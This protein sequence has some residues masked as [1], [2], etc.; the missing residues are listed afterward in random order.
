MSRCPGKK[1]W[2]KPCLLKSRKPLPRLPLRRGSAAS[3][4]APARV[5]HLEEKSPT[6]TESVPRG[7]NQTLWLLIGGGVLL[8]IVLVV[9][10]LV[11]VQGPSQPTVVQTGIPTVSAI[12]KDSRIGTTTPKSVPQDTG[13]HPGT[14][15][16]KPSPT[17][18]T[19]KEGLPALIQPAKP[20]DRDRLWAEFLD[21]WA[22]DSEPA[23]QTP[24]LRVGRLLTGLPQNSGSLEAAWQAAAADRLTILEIN[25]NGPLYL[26]TLPAVHGRSL[27]LRAGKGYRPLLIWEPEPGR[28]EPFIEFQGGSLTL[29]GLDVAVKATNLMGKDRPFLVRVRDGDF[30][31]R[32]CTF[33]VAGQ[34]ALGVALVRLDRSQPGGSSG[35]GRCRLSRCFGRGAS[36]VALDL[37]FPGAQVLLEGCLLVGSEQPLIQVTGRSGPPPV[38]RVVRSTLVTGQGMMVV[39]PAENQTQP[40]LRWHGWDVLLACGGGQPGGALLAVAGGARTT[41]MEWQA[42]NCLYA[43]WKTLLRAADRTITSISDWHIQWRLRE[44]DEAVP[45]AWPAALPF[46]P[47]ETR[48]ADFGPAPSPATPVGF[49]ATSGTGLLGCDPALLPPARDNWVATFCDGSP[50]PTVDLPTDGTPPGISTARDGHY[51]GGPVNLTQVGDLGGFL[52]KMSQTMGLGQRIVLHLQGQGLHKT[53]PLRVKGSSL[54]LYFP[55]LEK[56]VPRL[57][58]APQDTVSTQAE[59]LV[60]V[61]NGSLEMI[62]GEIHYPDY[63]LALLPPYV[64]RVRDGDLRLFRCRLCRK[65][66][67]LGQ[68]PEN[69]RGLIRFE[70]SGETDRARACVLNESLLVTGKTGLHL[71]GTGARVRLRQCVVLCGTDALFFEVGP[72]ARS[73]LNL[74]CALENSTLAAQRAVIHLADAPQLAVLL[75]P[76]VLQGRASAFL[77]PFTALPAP[78]VVLAVEGNALN[79]G[80]LTWQ[81]E[82]NVFDRR[83]STALGL[84]PSQAPAASPVTRTAWWGRSWER[85]QVLDLTLARTVDWNKLQFNRLEL[86]RRKSVGEDGQPKVV[87]GADL[88]L[89]GLVEKAKSS[90]R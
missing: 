17:P 4:P 69:F 40:G 27:L 78:P 56:D 47:A 51:H 25:D 74:Q 89:L 31:A 21:P 14:A 15:P 48:S 67:P 73:A 42:V 61:E 53:R 26:S 6:P 10:V 12:G 1:R 86:P 41:H 18:G 9:V 64:L 24:L 77:N 34:Q 16:I 68:G 11:M 83:L 55:P 71:I 72:A 58:L 82:G 52:E 87:P 33:S 84:L 2:R 90:S 57:V 37:D 62:N 29:Q 39:Q 54:V 70:G 38:L 65:E 13:R 66:G 49:A 36:L 43:G 3:L 8:A 81:G 59:A 60:E 35:G 76:I 19:E 22:K 7:K 32:D 80:L 20:L 45:Q 75:E 5:S 23:A 46:D 85:R 30:T 79:R 63:R 50:L 44:G 28:S 88:E